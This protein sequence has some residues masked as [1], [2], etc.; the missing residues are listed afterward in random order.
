MVRKLP[1]FVATLFEALMNFLLDIEDE[2][3]WHRVRGGLLSTYHITSLT[4]LCVADAL[5][6]TFQWCALLS[7]SQDI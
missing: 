2:P 1:N 7:S 5:S 4:S 6:V 3:D